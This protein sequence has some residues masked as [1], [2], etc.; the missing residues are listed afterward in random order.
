MNQTSVSEGLLYLLIMVPM[1]AVVWWIFSLFRRFCW[2]VRLSNDAI[3]VVIFGV[4][5]VWRFP[6]NEV[7]KI[8]KT[9]YLQLQKFSFR[10][11][12]TSFVNSFGPVLLI[13]RMGNKRPLAVSPKNADKFIAE[14]YERLGTSQH[15]AGAQRGL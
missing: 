6:L 10:R 2:R 4:V 15:Q 1:A 3:V 9:T 5:P 11:R 13:E 12:V 8:E 7:L 14:I